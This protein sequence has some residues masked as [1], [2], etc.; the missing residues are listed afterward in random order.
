MEKYCPWMNFAEAFNQLNFYSYDCL[1]LLFARWSIW[2]GTAYFTSYRAMHC[3]LES[4][5][6]GIQ[7][8]KDCLCIQYLICFTGYFGSIAGSCSCQRGTFL[9]VMFRL[10]YCHYTCNLWP[11]H[12]HSFAGNSDS[13]KTKD[14]ISTI[15]NFSL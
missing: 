14:I 13:A 8:W 1:F 3:C 5:G 12:L 9:A 7:Y 4:A 15:L 2:N 10:E 6:M 11:F